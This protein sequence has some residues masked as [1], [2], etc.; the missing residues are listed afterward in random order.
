MGLTDDGQSAVDVQATIAE[1]RRLWRESADLADQEMWACHSAIGQL[2]DA[3][4]GDDPDGYV[5]EW[6]DL[7]GRL[8][9]LHEQSRRRDEQLMAAYVA[10][11]DWPGGVGV[12]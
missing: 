3:G 5:A 7:T 10:R 8:V 4:P 9:E 6:R 11:I 2:L 1:C 12:E